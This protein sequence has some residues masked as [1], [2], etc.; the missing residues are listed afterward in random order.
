MDAKHVKHARIAAALAGVL[1]LAG[2][3]EEALAFCRTS[4]CPGA[5]T[6][7]VCTPKEASDCGIPLFWPSSCV[8]FSMQQ[9]GSNQVSLSLAEQ[10]FE[11]AFAR[12]TGALCPGGGKPHIRVVNMGPVACDKHEYSQSDAI[13]NANIMIFRDDAWPHPGAGSTLALTTVTYNKENG[14]IYDADMEINS[15]GTTL[16]TTDAGVQFDLASIVTHET[17]HFLGLAHS[18]AAGATMTTEYKS[19]SVDLRDLSD[20]DV[21]GICAIYPPG[22]AIPETCDATPRHG[23]QGACEADVEPDSND[24]CCA[25]APGLGGAEREGRA[26][27]ALAALAALAVL[28]GRT[29]ARRRA[30]RA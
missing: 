16:T 2:A 1:A 17:G 19:G 13:G 5:G 23:F 9:D 3:P 25:I 27:G 6:S 12:W 29:R 28:R 11:E 18:S 14:E 10:I 22:P 15:F 26:I 24:G 8:G 7:Q 4:S 20:D 21:Q 30:T